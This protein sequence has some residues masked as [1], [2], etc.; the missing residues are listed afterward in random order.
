ML[1]VRVVLLPALLTPDD[2]AGRTVVVFDVLRATTTMAV[3]LAAG[4]AAVR[5]Y[6]SLDDARAAAAAFD[7]PKLLAGELHA[8]KPD[9]FDAGNSPAEFTPASCAGR[10]LLMATTNG[11]RALVAARAAAVLATG[12]IVNAAATA[13]AIIGTGLPVTLLCSGT[14][15]FVSGED[16]IGCGAVLDAT[17]DLEPENDAAFLALSA[18]QAARDRLDLTFRDFRS[19]HNLGR[20]DLLGDIADVTGLDRLP[21]ACRVTDTA[22]QLVVRRWAD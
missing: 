18:W 21:V 22:G 5:V 10:T 9:G 16:A 2:L 3:A 4:A 6:G 15:G 11:T 12:A 8:R 1:L 20:A 19:G 14:E 13:E 17:P 7:G